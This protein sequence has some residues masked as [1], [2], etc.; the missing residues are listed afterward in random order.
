MSSKTKHFS[1]I[2]IVLLTA[3]IVTKQLYENLDIDLETEVALARK[4]SLRRHPWEEP[5]SKWNPCFSEQ[6]WIVGLSSLRILQLG[7]QYYKCW[8]SVNYEIQ[9]GQFTIT[10][11]FFCADQQCRRRLRASMSDNP[12]QPEI[13]H[14]CKCSAWELIRQ[15]SKTIW[16]QLRV[17]IGKHGLSNIVIQGGDNDIDL[18]Q[19]EVTK[20]NG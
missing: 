6:H 20:G 10:A 14:R 16:S 12:L 5:E 15:V 2:C 18:H 4:T 3:D 1:S 17:I 9:T 13:S 19:S 11:G 7:K 8:V